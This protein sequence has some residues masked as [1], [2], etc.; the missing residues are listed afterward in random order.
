MAFNYLFSNI[1]IDSIQVIDSLSGWNTNSLWNFEVDNR[2][3]FTVGD[4]IPANYRVVFTEDE[5][6]T[7]CYCADWLNTTLD[8]CAENA[9]VYGVHLFCILP[10]P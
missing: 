8:P 5:Y 3:A 4:A 10:Q 1:E 2:D 9:P 7:E 6:E